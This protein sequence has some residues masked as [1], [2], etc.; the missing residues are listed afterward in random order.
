MLVD[1]ETNFDEKLQQHLDMLRLLILEE[2]KTI[3]FKMARDCESQGQPGKVEAGGKEFFA[4]KEFEPCET[5]KHKERVGEDVETSLDDVSLQVDLSEAPDEAQG[6]AKRISQISG[7]SYAVIGVGQKMSTGAT[8]VCRPPCMAGVPSLKPWTKIEPINV[9]ARTSLRSGVGVVKTLS[10]RGK[11]AKKKESDSYALLSQAARSMSDD[12]GAVGQNRALH[13][14]HMARGEIFGVSFCDDVIQKINDRALLE[15]DDGTCLKSLRRKGRELLADADTEGVVSAFMNLVIASNIVLLGFQAGSNWEGWLLVDALYAAI[16][17]I[18]ILLRF[19]LQGLHMLNPTSPEF[20]G[21][22]FDIGLACLA[23]VDAVMSYASSNDKTS[24]SSILRIARLVRIARMLRLF[25]LDVFKDLILMI[26]GAVGGVRTLGWSIVMIFV[27]LYAFALFYTEMI[28]LDAKDHLKSDVSPNFS[29]IA[30]SMFTGFNCL[31]V[32]DCTAM[33][34]TPIFPH[35]VQQYGWAYGLVYGLTSVCMTFGLF[36]VIVA[37]YVENTVSAAKANEQAQRQSRL[38]D[39][40]RF[41]EK[42]LILVHFLWTQKYEG[43]RHEFTLDAG[44]QMELPEGLIKN[45]IT[46]PEMLQMLSDLDIPTEDHKDLFEICDADGSGIV[47]MSE[48]V[49]GIRKLRGDPRRSDLV[50]VMLRISQ[51][52]AEFHVMQGNICEI[53]ETHLAIK[54]TGTVAGLGG[55]I[56]KS[57]ALGSPEPNPV[58]SRRFSL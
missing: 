18:E 41:A 44:L 15:N 51:L 6:N 27:P 37:I 7:E 46:R 13:A 34:G 53:L 55:L 14:Q 2:H 25:Q 28:G 43:S 31:V 40:N 57:H 49:A 20:T 3:L 52:L 1:F 19:A 35:M 22:L 16:Y 42:M 24:N 5:D 50:Y 17:T 12:L 23:V 38:E 56:G 47:T 11:C 33:N 30:M 39:Q 48:L 10:A 21:S 29:S 54:R 9:Q 32:G 8:G 4:H 45:L 36:N 26:N 58:L